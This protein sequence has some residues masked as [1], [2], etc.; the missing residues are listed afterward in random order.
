[1]TQERFKGKGQEILASQKP[2]SLDQFLHSTDNPETTENRDNGRPQLHETGAMTDSGQTTVRE[3]F[4]CPPQLSDRLNTYVFDHKKIKRRT[5]KTQ[6]VNEALDMF[7]TGKGYWP[8]TP[9]KFS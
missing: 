2:S 7:L 3:E 4:R 9:L 8:S 1:M 6:V 5:S